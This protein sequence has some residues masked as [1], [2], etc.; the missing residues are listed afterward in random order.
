MTISDLKLQHCSKT[1]SQCCH[2]RQWWV[3]F[4]ISLLVVFPVVNQFFSCNKVWR[5]CLCCDI[6]PTRLMIGV[7]VKQPLFESTCALSSVC[8]LI[9]IDRWIIRAVE[10]LCL[11]QT[12]TL[13]AF[14]HMKGNIINFLA[15]Q[16][17]KWYKVVFLSMRSLAEH[18]HMT[19][20]TAFRQLLPVSFCSQL[21]ELM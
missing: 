1:K 20:Q 17:P 2:W 5:C 15:F 3:H 21:M 12:S 9:L 10:V 7:S 4:K 13:N 6:C 16:M 19:L 11:D 18:Y 8:V 14:L